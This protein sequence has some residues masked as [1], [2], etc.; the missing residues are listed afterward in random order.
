MLTMTIQ[1]EFSFVAWSLCRQMAKC[2]WAGGELFVQCNRSV[3]TWLDK[4][5]H[6]AREVPTLCGGSVYALQGKCLHRL[7]DP[8]CISI[9]GWGSRLG[10]A[11]WLPCLLRNERLSRMVFTGGGEGLTGFNGTC[12][13][14]VTSKAY[15]CYHAWPRRQR[16]V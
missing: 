12:L 8:P 5:L 2:S 14:G 3:N 6:F 4:C 13:L 15:L 7:G 10:R 16:A 1:W 11:G 9:L